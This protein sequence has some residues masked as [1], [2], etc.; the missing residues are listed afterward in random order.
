M[1]L[2]LL[3]RAGA[4]LDGHLLARSAVAGK[5][6]LQRVKTLTDRL[7]VRLDRRAQ[8]LAQRHER[9]VAPPARTQRLDAPGARRALAR[10][11]LRV[12]A[13]GRELAPQLR[14]A[15]R[16]RPL[17]GRRAALLDQP[18]RAPALLA[19]LSQRALGLAQLVVARVASLL[20]RVHALQRVFHDAPR[21][22]LGAR[23]RPVKR[24]RPAAL[25]AL[26]QRLAKA[27]LDDAPDLLPGGRPHAALARLGDHLLGPLALLASSAQR[28]LQL[29]DAR[30]VALGLALQLLQVTL[31]LLLATALELVELRLQTG[32]AVLVLALA[33]RRGRLRRGRLRG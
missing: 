15:Q 16:K 11:L 23:N 8:S 9:R 19:G 10:D 18:F 27:G 4:Q 14:R 20:G 26:V 12:S 32:D 13:F 3:A 29:G 7:R 5:L 1:D 17:L 21:N 25:V 2:G 30:R 28:P 24:Q 31:Q 6:L 22:L 33:R